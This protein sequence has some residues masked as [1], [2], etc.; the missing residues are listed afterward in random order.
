MVQSVFV[1]VLS[2]NKCTR[3]L[4]VPIQKKIDLIMP[5]DGYIIVGIAKVAVE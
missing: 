1:V 5:S 4:S 3:L 2:P